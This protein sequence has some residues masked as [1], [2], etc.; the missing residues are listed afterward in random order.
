[1]VVASGTRTCF[2]ENTFK[3]DVTL[4][5][6]A[7][8]AGSNMYGAYTGSGTLYVVMDSAYY[9]AAIPEMTGEFA[10][11][12]PLSD[13]K[14]GLY[15]PEGGVGGDG[16]GP[17]PPLKSTSDDS[18]GLTPLPPLQPATNSGGGLQPLP[19][20]KPM[21][22]QAVGNGTMYWNASDIKNHFIDNRYGDVGQAPS[23]WSPTSLACEVILYTNGNGIIKTQVGV[24]S[25]TFKAQLVKN[26]KLQP[27]PAQ[28]STD[29]SVPLQPLQPAAG[30]D[31]P[32]SPL[33]PLQPA[34]GH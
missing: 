6:K 18:G 2:E 5:L 1:M 28:G 27:Q 12:G 29:S 32:L 21:P 23:W 25:L 10:G 14:F 30:N 31:N 16:L 3:Y 19:P 13:I 20:L 15:V 4:D 17:L 7:I 22:T 11:G 9:H 34:A 8:N 26:V 33:P 24:W